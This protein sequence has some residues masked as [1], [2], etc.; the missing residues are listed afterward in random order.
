MNSKWNLAR[1]WLHH[2]LVQR[3]LDFGLG[4][5]VCVRARACYLGL[6]C[7]GE[8]AQIAWWLCSCAQH[9]GIQQ[10]MR[11]WHV[12]QCTILWLMDA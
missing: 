7:D 3:G 2:L 12:M 5:C 1:G 9:L 4:V 6:L 8:M 11:G 10:Q